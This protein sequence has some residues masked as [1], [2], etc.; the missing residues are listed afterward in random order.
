MNEIVSIAGVTGADGRSSFFWQEIKAIDTI[1]A[2]NIFFIMFVL[3]LLKMKMMIIYGLV[4][5]NFSGSM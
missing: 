4:Y 1:A 5:F 2:N 3:N